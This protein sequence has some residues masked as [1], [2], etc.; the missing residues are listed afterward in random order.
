VAV[1]HASALT[2]QLR[3]ITRAQPTEYKGL[4]L[5]AFLSGAEKMLLQAIG[6]SIHLTF[7]L[8]PRLEPVRADETQLLQVA[9]NLAV[10]ARDAMQ[11]KGT[12]TLRTR[13]V[14]IAEKNLPGLPDSKAGKWVCLS[15]SD[16]GT[17]MGKNQLEHLF[18]PFFT[19]KQLGK[20]TGLG[21]SVVYGIVEGHGGWIHVDSDPGK[22]S[23][24]Q[25]FLRV[26]DA[27]GA[28]GG[29]V[30]TGRAAFPAKRI[31]LVE[32]DPVVRELTEEILQDLN[33]EVCSVGDASKGR[34]AFAQVNGAFDLLF[35][36]V[37]LPDGDGS[38]LA[39]QLLEQNPGIPALLCSGSD[40]PGV[41]R[42][43]R[44]KGFAFVHKPF[45]LKKLLDEV[46]LAIN[47][48]EG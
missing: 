20:G 13:N 22:G 45:N 30:P 3:S 14:E 7:D 6:G 42:L 15:V 38:E 47:G 43:C 32:D 27:A 35:I 29:D 19:T 9:I 46:N 39:G 16:T 2:R 26:H 21:L 23:V 36:D 5:N 12:I 17:G 11:E 10:N 8:A 18:E 1:K 41:E 48:R 24:F 31:L 25:I 33:Y 28:A 44:E 34:K 37:M 4:D 40:D